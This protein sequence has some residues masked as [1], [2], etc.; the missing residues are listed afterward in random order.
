MKLKEIRTK[1]GLSQSQ[2]A[3][4]SGVNLRTLQQYEQGSRDINGAS[5]KSLLDLCIA[6]DCK[7]P[8]I[9]TDKD[10]IEKLNTI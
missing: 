6:L 7:L 5:L 4:K 3:K 9:L 8:D 10:L 1:N 2:L